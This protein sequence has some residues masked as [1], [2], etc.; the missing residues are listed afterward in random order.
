MDQTI[1]EL[2]QKIDALTEQVA[3]LAEE[4]RQQ[5]TATPGMGRATK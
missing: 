5:K 4:T 1:A 2:N 3:F